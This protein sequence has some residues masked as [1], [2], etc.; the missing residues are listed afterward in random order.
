MVHSIAISHL[1][2]NEPASGW[3]GSML[4]AL[5]SATKQIFDDVET[6]KT[7]YSLTKQLHDLWHFYEQ[8]RR[9]MDGTNNL[10]GIL[11]LLEHATF[12]LI[13]LGS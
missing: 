10:F 4:N 9:R 7:K 1:R 12:S 5:S 3:S 6:S 13:M 2:V 8:L 11:V